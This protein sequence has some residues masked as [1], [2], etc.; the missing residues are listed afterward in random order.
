MDNE[1]KE[2]D[3]YRGMDG[4]DIRPELPGDG[5]RKEKE[6]AQQ[7]RYG[8][9]AKT[10]LKDAESG[11][12]GG[13]YKNGASVKAQEELA[14]GFRSFVGGK[15]SKGKGLLG[16]KFKATKMSAAIVIFLILLLLVPIM[17]FANPIF[18]IGNFDY[19]LM[20]SIGFLRRIG[21]L[22]K[23]A[24]F[25]LGADLKK[26]EVS[27]QLAGK[28]AEHGLTVGQVTAKGD[29][30]RT[31]SYVAD[32]EDLADLA[33]LGSFQNNP[34]NGQLAVLFDNRVI[35]ADD[36][37]AVME[38]DPKMYM[39]FLDATDI[40]AAY[41]YSDEM[42]RELDRLDVGYL[43]SVF[44]D[45][46]A[47]GDSAKDRESY[48]KVKKDA[49]NRDLD[50]TVNSIFEGSST[51]SAGEGSNE[52]N[53]EPSATSK[54]VSNDGNALVII[55]DVAEQ[56]EG[57]DIRAANAKATQALNTI[58]SANESYVAAKNMMFTE[59]IIQMARIDGQGPIHE[60][61]GDLYTKKRSMYRDAF[62]KE[63]TEAV[64]S[65]L[66]S[67]TMSATLTR[68]K[69][70]NSEASS[71]SRD[72]GVITM[73]SGGLMAAES[74]ARLT[75]LVKEEDIKDTVISKDGNESN[76][77]VG[78][79][80]GEKANKDNLR[81]LDDGVDKTIVQVNSDLFLGIEGGNR[82]PEGAEFI[83]NTVDS[84]LIGAISSSE[85][86]VGE[87]YREAQDMVARRAEAERATKSPFDVS[88]PY[89][90]MGS[91]TRN[92][93]S[94]ML[95]SRIGDG[96]IIGTTV[97]VVA[98]ITN[99]SMKSFYAT[100][101]ADGDDGSYEMAIGDYCETPSVAGA[102]SSVLCG[103]KYTLTTKYMDLSDDALET[104]LKN[105]G[106]LDDDGTIVEKG[107]L[108]KFIVAQTSRQ[109]TVGIKDAEVCKRFKE[110]DTDFWGSIADAVAS[111]LGM[112][113]VC[114]RIEDVATNA[115][116]TLGNSNAEENLEL[117][118][119]YMMRD[120]V[121]SLLNG[122]E[123]SVAKFKK[124]YYEKHPLD[125]SREGILARRSGLTKDEVRVAL[126][127]ADYLMFIARYNPAERYAFGVDLM[128][129]EAHEPLVE[130]A[131]QIAADL[132]VM[133]HGHTEYDD[134]R[135]RTRVA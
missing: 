73:N 65:V 118:S 24:S 116:Y 54:N 92:V 14:G 42:N 6:N 122:T 98:N 131:S 76:V 59:S 134:L 84:H 90:F 133:W 7:K 23:T 69:F 32:I 87:Y 108:G 68:G 72:R 8:E 35:E 46:R 103:P 80:F 119:A 89:T 125:E 39:A 71:L 111:L 25:V 31:N 9:T 135:I 67:A 15:D 82:I 58:M 43:R 61:M 129:P 30:V 78:I 17:T 120:E 124:E 36:F 117:Y 132:Y 66:S 45:W 18:Q 126:A 2:H 4:P 28:L 113:K 96:G 22:E 104:E 83:M 130:H 93:G 110:L 19:N 26:G 62:T 97:G 64:G 114:D 57:D 20:D 21:I 77:F 48:E 109:S 3:P 33:V 91:L 13:L 40:G 121:K 107:G 70:S 79:S 55:D 41:W 27:D 5:S 101:I 115:K 52:S 60:L 34:S 99:D 88:S 95:K 51:N 86:K 105:S 12:S 106:S 44:S 56:M 49:L 53:N 47:S 74:D 11:A 81:V 29:F 16:G 50:L 112:Y 10:E 100:T 127:Y 123:S 102:G 85:E 128:P 1:L 94:T 75:A 63:M 37:V 38:S